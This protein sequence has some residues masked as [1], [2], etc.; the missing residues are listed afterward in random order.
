MLLKLNLLMIL[1]FSILIVPY[2]INGSE[3]TLVYIDFI[4]FMSVSLFNALAY[5]S[6]SK[7][8]FI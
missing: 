2:S 8:K 5:K 4:F 3:K 7:F 6:V 1:L